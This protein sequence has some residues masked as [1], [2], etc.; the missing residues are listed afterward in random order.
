MNEAWW[1][2]STWKIKSAA[3]CRGSKPLDPCSALTSDPNKV[4]TS[5]A[6]LAS[7]HFGCRYIAR[8]RRSGPKLPGCNHLVEVNT[9]K[10]PPSSLQT[11]FQV[12]WA[13]VESCYCHG[14]RARLHEQQCLPG[15]ILRAYTQLSGPRSAED[16]S[17]A[18]L[19]GREIITIRA[20]GQ[21]NRRIVSDVQPLHN[22]Y[23][24]VTMVNPTGMQQMP[25]YDTCEDGSCQMPAI[26]ALWS[27]IYRLA[28]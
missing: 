1:Q 25:L 5:S 6:F 26:L 22:G 24:G 21:C 10:D 19:L 15:S 7:A 13:A 27:G 8:S 12:G 23:R 3:A 4:S 16:V 14:L 20:D 17:A 28:G 11:A 2:S 9:K 18:G